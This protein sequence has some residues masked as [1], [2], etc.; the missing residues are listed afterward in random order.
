MIEFI[1]HKTFNI[2]N[3]KTYVNGRECY[4]DKLIL[5]SIDSI[6]IT[7]ENIRDVVLINGIYIVTFSNDDDCHIFY[8]ILKR[9]C[10]INT[11]MK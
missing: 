5:N 10:I 6:C 9:R 11:I 4:C 2:G 1:S 8:D 7:R 3:I